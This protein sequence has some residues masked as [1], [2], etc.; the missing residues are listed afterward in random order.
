[1]EYDVRLLQLA[2]VN[3]F[4]GGGELLKLKAFFYSDESVWW[5]LRRVVKK[6]LPARK[7]L[8]LNDLL[9]RD[10]QPW[11]KFMTTLG[12]TPESEVLPSRRCAIVADANV[13]NEKI[14]QD[15][16]VSTCGLVLFFL[17]FISDRRDGKDKACGQRLLA[18]FLQQVVGGAE[19]EEHWTDCM[20]IS[21][22][23]AQRCAVHQFRGKCAHVRTVLSEIEWQ[24]GGKH[25][26]FVVALVRFY[27]NARQC[28]SLVHYLGFAVRALCKTLDA[29]VKELD[30]EEDILKDDD[31][32]AGQCRKL[33][34]D[35]DL[36][37]HISDAVASGRATHTRAM[38]R[39]S[40]LII[41][42]SA[43]TMDSKLL[44][45]YQAECWLR[46][47]KLGD[48]G[49][50]PDGTRCGNPAEESL[51]IPCWL[52]G[53]SIGVVLPCQVLPISPSTA[54]DKAI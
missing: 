41:A 47:K 52:D 30:L 6:L 1:M 53:A 2:A 13:T 21:P 10:F 3:E 45:E 18:S 38:I 31:P 23:D 20:A 25:V 34:I 27:D 11:L 15:F 54:I 12:F 4:E 37:M 26:Q 39:A 9:K 29:H 46:A 43:R 19:L 22:M 24:S 48:V 14:R 8:D 51:Q 36:Q 40:G 17:F 35:E 44:L 16:T 42:G 50:C 28:P 33:R 5:E 32:I 49:V 7:D